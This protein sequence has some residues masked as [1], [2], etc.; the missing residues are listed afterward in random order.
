M[1]MLGVNS[2]RAPVDHLGHQVM[3]DSNAPGDVRL[4]GEFPCGRPVPAN[5]DKLRQGAK[6][7]ATRFPPVRWPRLEHHVPWH[8]L[9]TGGRDVIVGQPIERG[10]RAE[11]F[12]GAAD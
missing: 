1:H 4:A 7:I 3:K 12:L 8:T 9:I 10:D 2:Q 11:G 6:H 5:R